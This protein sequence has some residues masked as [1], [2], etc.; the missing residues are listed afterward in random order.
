MW[1]LLNKTQWCGEPKGY[2]VGYRLHNLSG[3]SYTTVNVSHTANKFWLPKN[4]TRYVG[5]K[6]YVAAFTSVGLGPR[7]SRGFYLNDG[8]FVVYYS[9]A[10]V[11]HLRY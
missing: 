5:Y 1:T 9:S 4:L 6:S 7:K 8:E 10:C 3:V 2:Q 11:F